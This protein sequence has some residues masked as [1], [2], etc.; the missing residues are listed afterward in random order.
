MFLRNKTISE[1][2]PPLFQAQIDMYP[3]MQVCRVEIFG[4]I[5]LSFSNVQ[6]TA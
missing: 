1:A 6:V 2:Q 5:Q 3:E 4:A